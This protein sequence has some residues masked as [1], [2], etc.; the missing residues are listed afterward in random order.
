MVVRYITEMQ[1]SVCLK[2]VNIAVSLIIAPFVL[3]HYIRI[4]IA[5]CMC[6]LSYRRPF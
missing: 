5:L 1:T 2:A 6:L 4:E 3:I